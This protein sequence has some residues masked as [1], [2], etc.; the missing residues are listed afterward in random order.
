MKVPADFTAW[1]VAMSRRTFLG[2]A[3]CGGLSAC[4]GGTLLNAYPGV[5]E[6]NINAALAQIDPMAAKLMAL[7]GL[8]GMAVAVVQG[9]R[10]AYAKGFGVRQVGTQETVDADTVFQLASLSKSVGAT[11]VAHQVGLGQVTWDTPMHSLLP[12]FAL[13]DQATS[14]Q[15]T[16]AD[17][18][19][20]RSGLPHY[21]GD[22]LEDLGFGRRQVLERLRYLPLAPLRSSYAYTNFG[23]TAAA[24][25]VAVTAGV[26]WS[27][28][29]AQSLYQTLGMPNTSSRYAD[30]LGRAN[31]AVGHVRMDGQWTQGIPRRT[32][33][34]SPAGGVSSSIN[35]MAKWLSMVL[36]QGAYGGQRIV[37]A[38]ALQ[39]ALSP[40]IQTN[41]GSVGQTPQYYGYGFNVGRTSAGRV[42]YSHSGAF[43]VGAATTFMILPGANLAIIVLTNGLP[44]GIPETLCQQFIDLLEYGSIQKDWW[45]LYSNAF[46]AMLA[47]TGTLLGV[48]RPS[49]PVASGPPASYVGG[50]LND[51][52][53]P[54]QLVER[55]GAL[56]FTLGPAGQIFALTHWDGEVFTFSPS[57][58][59]AS[60]GTISKAS[61]NG[62]QLTLEFYDAEGLGTFVR[63]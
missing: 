30:F 51:Y 36:G 63:G 47:P 52:Y 54:L 18:Y 3:L 56:A 7:T 41:S 40:Q 10:L 26:E 27:S 44:L 60:P 6:S 19:A 5:P 14:A 12:W 9:E 62:S 13:S 4:G 29:S 16:V 15:L 35:D 50:Y 59:S 33:E 46:A 42:V 11:V 24:E 17:L 21:A 31:R 8:P 58:E 28:L 61:F 43:A 57:G 48:P 25:G 39:A 45:A 32:D 22:Y 55:N 49:Q 1:D 2:A 34:Q 53:G 20:H 37:D 23:I 38:T